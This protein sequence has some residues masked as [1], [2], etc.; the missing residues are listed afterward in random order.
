MKK[1][2]WTI[3]ALFVATALFATPLIAFA[4]EKDADAIANDLLDDLVEPGWNWINNA[5]RYYDEELKPCYNWLL[6]D[7]A[8]YYVGQDDAMRT[9][10]FFVD[11]AWYYAN[12]KGIM[13]T[14]WFLLDNAWYYTNLSGVMQT[15]WFFVDT[16]WYYANPSGVMLTG[17]QWIAGS[18]Y[19]L[20]PNGAMHTYWLWDG[21]WYFL[22]PTTGVM[23]ANAWAQGS[24]YLLANGHMAYGCYAPGDYWLNW[25]GCWE[26]GEWLDDTAKYM[27][28]RAQAYTSP[29][30]WL[31][32]VDD[33]ACRA[34]IFWGCS[35]TWCL[36]KYFPCATGAPGTPTIKGTYKVQSKIYHFGEEKGYT[37]YYATQFSGDYL[38]HSIL[39][40]KNSWT[41]Q[42]GR[43]GAQL[44]HGC[45]RLATE[46]A[47]YIYNNI[48]IG[49]TVVSY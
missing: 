3:T 25:S 9:G 32:I 21:A 18:W 38:L 44:S 7:N 5:W 35:G 22:D 48:P 14:G 40:N 47:Q 15:G 41:V 27:L 30:E 43:L 16:T 31:I 12:P 45:V 39:Y 19:Y 37:C 28:S 4:S 49:T 1:F 2:L 13:Q 10:W 34:G 33:A 29:T 23:Y 6:I 46:N 36:Y 24:Y 11:T 42:D 20:D 26:P 8:W 17:W